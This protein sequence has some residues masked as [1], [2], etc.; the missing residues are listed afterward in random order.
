MVTYDS[1][2]NGTVE[3]EVAAALSEPNKDKVDK[4]RNLS[5][6]PSSISLLFSREEGTILMKHEP[7]FEAVES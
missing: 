7:F 6:H 5:T 2:F 3:S 1:K 4:K